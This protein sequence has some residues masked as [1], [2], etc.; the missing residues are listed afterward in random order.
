MSVPW[1]NLPD[2]VW[3]VIL[4]HLNVKSLLTAT[5][6]CTRL[7]DVTGKSKKLMKMIRLN[8]EVPVNNFLE[9]F[10]GEQNKLKGFRRIKALKENLLMSDRNYQNTGISVLGRFRGWSIPFDAIMTNILMDICEIFTFF[11]RSIIDFKIQQS[12]IENK[13]FVKIISIFMN[14]QKCNI[15]DTE[16]YGDDDDFSLKLPKLEHISLLHIEG[17]MIENFLFSFENLKSLEIVDYSHRLDVQIEDIFKNLLMKQ[18][19]LKVFRARC[20]E[21]FGQDVLPNTEFSLDSLSLKCFKWKNMDHAESFFKKQINLKDIH[22]ELN[23]NAEG[24]NFRYNDIMKQIFSLNHNLSEISIKI[25]FKIVDVTFLD[26]I[27]RPEVETLS[28]KSSVENSHLFAALIKMC[29]KVKKLTFLSDLEDIDRTAISTL[30]ELE[31]LKIS[32]KSQSLQ[33]LIICSTR[34]IEFNIMNYGQ[35]REIVIFLR[36]HQSIE[37]LLIQNLNVSLGLCEHI[38]NYLPN[39]RSFVFCEL[40]SPTENM[41][42]LLTLKNLRSLKTTSIEWMNKEVTNLCTNAG[43]DIELSERIFGY[44]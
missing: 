10:H 27:C 40:E 39:L 22:L 5:E 18:K 42:L 17:L 9:G 6:T 12:N 8:I 15:E 35:E 14:L 32:T 34:F 26:G 11:S 25:L 37:H 38:V 20:P 19:H 31:Y 23:D 28:F 30:V 4:G 43:V 21:I 41:Q 16:I 29:P 44:D 1:L 13:V 2:E 36:N 3:E 7:N 33:N 24:L